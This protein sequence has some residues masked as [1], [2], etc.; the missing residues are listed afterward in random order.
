METKEAQDSKMVFGDALNR[1]A[2]ESDVPMLQ[3]PKA[4]E[5]VED[6]AGD[7]I[8]RERI[9]REVAPRR[10]T[11]PVVGEGDRGTPSICCYISSKRSDLYRLA[12]AHG[13]DGPVFDTCRNRL[14]LRRFEPP[15]DLIR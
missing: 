12:V 9:D 14:Y 5:I 3:I 11:A 13:S 15:H 4:T 1:V 8:G 6:L 10:V 2:D 7:R